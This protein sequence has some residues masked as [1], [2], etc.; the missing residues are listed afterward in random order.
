MVYLIFWH[1]VTANEILMAYLCGEW[2]NGPMGPQ[3]NG[4]LIPEALGSLLFTLERGN[5]W[6]Q[7]QYPDLICLLALVHCSL[8]SSA[9]TRLLL[10][11]GH[12]WCLFQG[13]RLADC[14]LSKLTNGLPT[15]I[16]RMKG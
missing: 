6:S 4:S 13:V 10:V 15:D 2:A 11:V 1:H 9:S 5:Y 14:R 16:G 12:F 7:V 8:Q 3:T